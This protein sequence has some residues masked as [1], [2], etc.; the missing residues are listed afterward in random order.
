LKDIVQS[1]CDDADFVQTVG[2]HAGVQLAR[3]NPLHRLMHVRESSIHQEPCHLI[4]QERHEQDAA[5]SEPECRRCLTLRYEPPQRT[6]RDG[7][8]GGDDEAEPDSKRE[9]GHETRVRRVRPH[10][11]AGNTCTASDTPRKCARRHCRSRKRPNFH[12]AVNESRVGR[13]PWGEVPHG[14]AI[15]R[16]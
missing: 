15:V 13:A 3:C 4:D 5:Y 11:T 14:V 8:N 2:G 1:P 10:L 16:G 6:D 7:G 12:Y 9:C